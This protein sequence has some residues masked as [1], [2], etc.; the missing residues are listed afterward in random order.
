MPDGTDANI[1][2]AF[3]LKNRMPSYYMDDDC[4]AIHEIQ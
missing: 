1:L 3:L 4:P 2:I